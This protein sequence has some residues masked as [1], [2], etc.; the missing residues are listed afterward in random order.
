MRTSVL[1]CE[2]ASGAQAIRVEEPQRI[3][4]ARLPP[5]LGDAV[6][7]IRHFDPDVQHPRTRIGL[8][9]RLQRLL[10]CRVGIDR[11]KVRRDALIARPVQGLPQ[12]EP[13]HRRRA[14]KAALRRVG[15]LV[16]APTCEQVD[17]PQVGSHRPCGPLFEPL[18]DRVGP[19]AVV[20]AQH[21]ELARRLLPPLHG[22]L[23]GLW[24]PVVRR[25]GNGAEAV[26]LRRLQMHQLIPQTTV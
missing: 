16:P 17:D 5:E 9:R 23:L 3:P 20:G 13:S 15:R 24:V 18:K 14:W 8:E 26:R 19:S 4:V 12:A 2:P 6:G 21:R 11:D 22:I 25:H 10:E 1:A 7:A